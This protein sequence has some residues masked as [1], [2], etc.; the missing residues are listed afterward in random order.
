ML[1]YYEHDEN[2]ASSTYVWHV[3]VHFVAVLNDYVC[4]ILYK[5][6]APTRRFNSW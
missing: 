4:S 6:V 1:D 2:I 3:T 5:S